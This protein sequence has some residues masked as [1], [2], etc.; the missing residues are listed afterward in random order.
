MPLFH[1][2]MRDRLR[3]AEQGADTVIWLAV[4]RASTAFPSGSFFQGDYVG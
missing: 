2:M 1:Q 3:S 4:S